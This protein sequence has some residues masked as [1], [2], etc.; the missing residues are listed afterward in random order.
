MI[1]SIDNT[2]KNSLAVIAFAID[3]AVAITAVA[4][5]LL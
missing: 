2:K 1:T 5:V 4:A 3:I